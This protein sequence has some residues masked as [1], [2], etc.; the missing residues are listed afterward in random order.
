MQVFINFAN[1]YKRFVYAFF[2]MSAKLI[3]LLKKT[4]KKIQNQ[5]RHDFKNE[6]FM[7]LIKKVFMNASMLRQYKLDDELIMK[8]NVFDYVITKIFSQLAKIDNQ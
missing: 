7:K 3:S 5:I 2:K 8:I 4:K 1:F 6:K